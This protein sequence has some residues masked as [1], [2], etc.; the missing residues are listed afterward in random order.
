[1]YGHLGRERATLAKFLLKLLKFVVFE[2]NFDAFILFGGHEK[3]T[4]INFL[5]KLDVRRAF[6]HVTFK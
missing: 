6:Y 5:F 4:K 2:E 1:M 3:G